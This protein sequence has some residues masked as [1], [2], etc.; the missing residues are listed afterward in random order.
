[1]GSGLIG[2]AWAM[3]FARAGWTVALTDPAPGA[4]EA[5]LAACR[6]GLDTLA[7]QGLCDDPAAALGRIT[8][9][10]SLAEAVADADYVQE[11]GPEVLDV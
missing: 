5:A 6:E 9:A 4:V 7:A 1:M 11:N 8:A 2:R 10:G 3:T